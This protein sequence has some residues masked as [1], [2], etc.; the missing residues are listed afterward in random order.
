MQTQRY[1]RAKAVATSGAIALFTAALVFSAITLVIDK[2]RSPHLDLAAS[3]SFAITSSVSSSSSSEIPAVLDPGTTRYLWYTVHNSLSVPVTVNS[4]GISSVTAPAGCPASNLDVSNTTF[5][6]SLVVAAKVGA[7]AGVNSVAVPITLIEAAPDSCKNVTFNFSFTGTATYEQVYDTSTAVASSQNPSTVGQSVTYTATVTGIVGSGQDPL[8]DGPTGT[9]TFKDGATTICADVAVTV[10]ATT[11]TAQCTSPV[12]PLPGSRSITAQ[13]THAADNNFTD[14]SS[15]T[16]TQVVNLPAA[17]SGSYKTI[18]GN[19]SSPTINGTNGNDF[20]SAFGANYTINA[21]QGSDCIVVGDG[22]NKITA[23]NQN[24]VIVAGHG[25]NTITAGN[26]ANSITVGNGSNNKV[27]AGNGSNTVVLGTGGNNTVKLGN[28]S[29]T[30]TITTPG[31]HNTITVGNG[32][33]TA[34]LGGG[35]FNKFTGGKKNNN[36]CHLPSLPASAY[37]DTLV[38]CTAVTP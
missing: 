23:G 28:G 36:T 31:H 11:S 26:G 34:Y 22:N 37:N 21:G 38:N 6:G 7:V 10:G 2:T 25:A 5:S 35:T 9:V 3:S 30:I 24:N 19:P 18:V 29:N 4:L 1:E 33:N 8:P 17:C 15:S 32:K 13:F 12:Y 20:I 27:T 16:F 14:S